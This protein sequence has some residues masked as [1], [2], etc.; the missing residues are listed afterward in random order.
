M[1]HAQAAWG[2]RS[3]PRLRNAGVPALQGT[4]CRRANDDIAEFLFEGRRDAR[5]AKNPADLRID[6]GEAGIIQGAPFV[7]WRRAHLQCRTL[8]QRRSGALR[9][10]RC[11]RR[12]LDRRPC[13]SLRGDSARPT[14][15]AGT[16]QARRP[17]ARPSAPLPRPRR[18]ASWLRRARPPPVRVVKTGW[19]SCHTQR[20]DG[21]D[22]SRR[23]AA[24]A[25]AHRRGRRVL[26]RSAPGEGRR[27]LARVRRQAR[28]RRRRRQARRAWELG[29]PELPVSVRALGRRGSVLRWASKRRRAG[30][31]W[32]L[33]A[34]RLTGLRYP[35]QP[36][37]SAPTRC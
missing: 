1:E 10:R 5:L 35:G 22:R 11:A 27:L 30:A 32:E 25:A 17:P 12:G 23:A 6:P 29:D 37:A 24:N 16:G 26:D 33:A 28:A 21:H 4:S 3:G 2:A 14:R 13:G 20:H 36:V 9:W 7:R 18:H 31:R 19:R 34:A 15:Q 8:A